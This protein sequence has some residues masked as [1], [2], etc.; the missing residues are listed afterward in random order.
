MVGGYS[1][2]PWEAETGRWAGAALDAAR[3]VLADPEERRRWLRHGETWFVGV[4]ALPNGPDGA[5]G[6]VPLPDRFRALWDGDWHPAQLSAVYPGY[7]RQDS[8]E[9]DAAHRFRRAR[10][11]AHVDGLLPEGPERRRVLR[12]PHAFILGL[13]LTDCAASPLVVWQGSPEVVTRHLRAA[14]GEVGLGTDVTEAYHAARRAVFETCRRVEVPARPGE[15]TLVHRLAVHGVAPWAAGVEAPEEG[16]VI[17]Y[18]RPQLAD[19]GAWLGG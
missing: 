5:L 6:G 9:S 17:A 2:L 7:P 3:E 16:R 4:D 14:H 10:D 1:V 12:E 18:F 11:A 8:E 13:P 19:C 15:A